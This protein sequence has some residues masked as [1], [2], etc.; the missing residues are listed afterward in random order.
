MGS[1]TA[2]NYIGLLS[3]PLLVGSVVCVWGG[4]VRL[5]TAVS[6][7]L[8][9]SIGA[10]LWHLNGHITGSAFRGTGT[11]VMYPVCVVRVC[12]HVCVDVCVGEGLRAIRAF[13]Q[14]PFFI[15]VSV[16]KGF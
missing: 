8:K 7:W 11:A 4:G 10:S 12:V 9:T 15:Q 6:I 16:W 3:F 14:C 13:S 5:G 2:W 1:G